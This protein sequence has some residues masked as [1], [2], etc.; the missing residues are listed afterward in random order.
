VT[1]LTAPSQ[2]IPGEPFEVTIRFSMQ[3]GWHI[4]AEKPA[5]PALIGTRIEPATGPF[6]LVSAT[7]PPARTVRLGF[8]TESLRVYTGEAVVRLRLLPHPGASAGNLRLR[9]RY[10]ACNDRVCERPVEMLLATGQR[11]RTTKP[12]EIKS[13]RSE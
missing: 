1:L 3:P 11:A 5:D 6:R 12:T 7:Y 4:N 8:R 10:Q 2:V 9:V 13:R